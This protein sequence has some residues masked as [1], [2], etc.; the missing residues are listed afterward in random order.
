MRSPTAQ[1]SLLITL[2]GALAVGVIILGSV[3]VAATHTG[4][5]QT[6]TAATTMRIDLQSDGHAQWTVTMRFSIESE[7]ESAAF[8]RLASDFEAGE[9]DVLAVDP[10]REAAD[11][12]SQTTG[13]SM[14]ITAVD[15]T[16]DRSS[17][18]LE[19]QFT[20]TKFARTSGDRLAL[21]DVFTTPSGT[22]L[23]RLT[24]RQTLIIEFPP[25]YS[26]QSSSRAL[27]NRTFSI[28]GPAAF[29][30]GEPSAILVRQ[31]P[32]TTTVTPN[33]V[34]QSPA[35][36]ISPVFGIGALLVLVVILVL[37]LERRRRGAGVP[38]PTSDGNGDGGP[39]A[40]ASGGSESTVDGSEP[41]S[42]PLLS[43]EERILRLLHNEGGRMKQAAIV[44]E[45]DWSNAKVS[46][47]L[48]E[49]ADNGD[50]DKLRIGREN[51]ISLPGELQDE[52]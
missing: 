20:W 7:N 39:M 34:T 27:E 23:P 33:S 32:G 26:V 41:D 48:T 47:L 43:D 13:R 25:S 46:Q 17:A 31:G 28:E 2:L 1:R 30:P 10:F 44:E 45:T 15:R 40:T 9:S 18:A 42:G 8:D 24:E 37:L 50:I 49:M 5:N 52:E 6:D 3:P 22:W 36:G 11:R 29:D 19:L 16:A 4:G 38:T 21:G 35:F 14:N 51:L 12:A